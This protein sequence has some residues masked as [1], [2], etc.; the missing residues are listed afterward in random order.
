MSDIRKILILRNYMFS[1][2]GGL[3]VSILA[4]GPKV[5]R[6]KPLWGD[7]FLRVIKSAQCLPLEGK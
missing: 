4:T 5:C 1:H 2:L 3:I 6:L 7:G